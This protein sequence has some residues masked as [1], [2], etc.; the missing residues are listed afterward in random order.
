MK[1]LVEIVSK[2][3]VGGTKMSRG[4]YCSKNRL[5]RYYFKVKVGSKLVHVERY[6]TT[7]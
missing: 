5:L 4:Y 6:E 3:V 2:V 7:N 1:I